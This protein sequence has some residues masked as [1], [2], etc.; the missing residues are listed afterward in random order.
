MTLQEQIKLD[1]TAAMK[2]RDIEK[3]DTLRVILG[4]F[5][6]LEKKELTDDEV[7]KILIK[8]IKNEKETLE[9]SGRSQES[10]YIRIIEGYLPRPADR[11][12]I[13]SWIKQNID[14]S[15]FNNK[16]QAMSLIMKHFGPRVEGNQ[17][18]GILQEL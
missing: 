13:I 15:G 9:K 16:M 17:V 3:K 11:E 8:L 14:F 7:I 5:G 4:E 18:K 12:E 2:S 1:L 6:R 10:V